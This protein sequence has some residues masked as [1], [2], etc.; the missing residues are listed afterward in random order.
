MQPRIAPPNRLG[1]TVFLLDGEIPIRVER[2]A[3]G[4]SHQGHVQVRDDHEAEQ[5]LAGQAGPLEG[6][7]VDVKEED[8]DFGEAEG[9]DVEEDAVP[10]CL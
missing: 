10:C 8:G 2:N 5:R 4:K 7:E 3:R 9:Q 1:V 6:E